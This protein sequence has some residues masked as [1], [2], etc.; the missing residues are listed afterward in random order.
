[1][2]LMAL[3]KQHYHLSSMCCRLKCIYD[4]YVASPVKWRAEPIHL[5]VQY[6]TI[7]RWWK[8]TID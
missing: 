6:S 1:M 8:L 2:V 3:G 5:T 7:S 4:Q